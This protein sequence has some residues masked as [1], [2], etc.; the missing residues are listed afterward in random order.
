MIYSPY[1]T[2]DLS[3]SASTLQQLGR[4]KERAEARAREAIKEG[5]ALRKK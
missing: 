2:R 5:A 3:K 4:D 1:L